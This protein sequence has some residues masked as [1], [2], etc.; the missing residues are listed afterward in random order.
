M[1]ANINGKEFR[2]EKTACDFLQN[3]LALLEGR[4]SRR[5]ALKEKSTYYDILN[6]CKLWLN[7][8]LI[9]NNFGIQCHCTMDIFMTSP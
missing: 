2:C 4:L 3:Q 5:G 8:K 7:S 6:L 9:V 1:I